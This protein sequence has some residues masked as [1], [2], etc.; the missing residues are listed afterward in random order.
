MPSLFPEQRVETAR[1][2]ARVDQ[3]AIAARRNAFTRQPSELLARIARPRWKR[4]ASAR[5]RDSMPR[6]AR[7]AARFAQHLSYQ[8][9]TARQTCTPRDFPVT[10]EIPAFYPAHGL[11]NRGRALPRSGRRTQFDPPVMSNV[12]PNVIAMDARQRLEFRLSWPE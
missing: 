11:A 4:D 3:Y 2:L 10:C 6:Q 5:A 1:R 7:L 12:M 8:T 9:R